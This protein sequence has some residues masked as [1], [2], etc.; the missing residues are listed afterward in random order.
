M[1]SS[2]LSLTFL[3]LWGPAAIRAA[4]FET[5]TNIEF[6]QVDGVSLKYDAFLLP[7][8]SH[9]ALIYVHGGGFTGG[10]KES[11]NTSFAEIRD[12]CLAA[13]ISVL[14]INYRLAPQFP[15]PAATND[16][17]TAIAFIKSHAAELRL[18]PDRL[19][20]IGDSAGGMIVS[21][22]GAKYAPG[23]RVKTVISMY[24]EHDFVLRLSEEP[25]AM[26]GYT[27]K[28]PVG[29]CISGG[30]AAFFG[31]AEATTAQHQE[32]VRDATAVTHVH[33]RMP[34]YLLVHGTRDYGVPI[35]Q[36]HSMQQAIHRV[37]AECKMIAVVGGGHG[38]TGWNQDHQRHYLAA[39]M[40]WL[41]EKLQPQ[42]E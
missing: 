9:P 35:E 25:C 8:K 28:R 24:G 26:D 27:K 13:G 18:D 17:Q 32:V 7:G 5:R 36:S 39:I 34:S 31:F 16:V 10:D 3:L 40:N 33:K 41:K 30:M 19:A 20:L 4:E 42:T 23:N 14:S 15:Y 12:H 37:G 29:G 22:A 2:L 6:A 21:H 1:K 11:I 38:H